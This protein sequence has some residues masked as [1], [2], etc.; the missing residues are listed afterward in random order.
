MSIHLSIQTED[1]EVEELLTFVRSQFPAVSTDEQISIMER[2]IKLLR[3]ADDYAFKTDPCA[4][5]AIR[6]DAGQRVG[7]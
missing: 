7:V 4:R 6:L 3:I 1:A 2:A 5:N